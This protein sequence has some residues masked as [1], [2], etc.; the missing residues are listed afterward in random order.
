MVGVFGRVVIL[1]HNS[2]SIKLHQ[3]ILDLGRIFGG[4]SILVDDIKKMQRG[5][6]KVT[7]STIIY[8][9]LIPVILALNLFLLLIYSRLKNEL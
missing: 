8:I 9:Q 5:P 6:S 2:S 3:H 1:K 7:S 4:K